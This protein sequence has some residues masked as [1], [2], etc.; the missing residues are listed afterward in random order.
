M[1]NIKYTLYNTQLNKLVELKI[2]GRDHNYDPVLINSLK[3]DIYYF[4]IKENGNEKEL[5]LNYKCYN[6]SVD[7]IREITESVYKKG[8]IYDN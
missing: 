6:Y 4:M 7:N 8:F 5:I 1:K 2:Y 3:S